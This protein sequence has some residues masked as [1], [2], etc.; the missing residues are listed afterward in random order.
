VEIANEVFLPT[1]KQ[2]EWANE[3]IR[4]MDVGGC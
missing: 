3:I 2:I 4:K 1:S